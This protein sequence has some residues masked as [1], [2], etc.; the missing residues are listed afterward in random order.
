MATASHL[1]RLHRLAREAGRALGEMREPAY[2][3]ADGASDPARR[4][5]ERGELA[6]AVR[7]VIAQDQRRGAANGSGGGCG[8]RS[9]QG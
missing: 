8:C 2:P 5:V 1:A 6:G 9:R 7:W 4:F 3:T